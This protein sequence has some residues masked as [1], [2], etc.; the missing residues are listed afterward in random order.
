MVWL[1]LKFKFPRK[2]EAIPSVAL[3]VEQ[4]HIVE[5]FKMLFAG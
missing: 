1:G 5:W 2:R 3:E 4:S